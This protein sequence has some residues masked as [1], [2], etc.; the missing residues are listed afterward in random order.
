MKQVPL[1]DAKMRLSELIN[2]VSE[3]ET[4]EITR[5]GRA[6]ARLVPADAP[7]KPIDFERLRKHISSMP[8]GETPA[9]DFVRQMR[10]EDRY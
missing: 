6:V 1:A 8:R 9:G 5:R 4:I 10:D 7:K 3:G 2:A